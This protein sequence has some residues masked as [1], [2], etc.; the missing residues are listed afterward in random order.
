MTAPGWSTHNSDERPRPR[1]SKPGKPREHD[2]T[3]DARGPRIQKVLAE[4]GFGSRRACEKLIE[5]GAVTVN[6]QPV[7]T[8]PAWVDPVRDAIV[9]NGKRLTLPAEHHYIMLYKP[10][11][12]VSTNDDPEGRKL[13][14]DLVKLPNRTRL[15]PVGRL[16]MDSTGLLLLT[17]DGELANRLTHPRYG[18]H[19]VYEV[20][21]DGRL[22]EVAAEKLSRG[23]FLSDAHTSHGKRH[24]GRTSQSRLA[25]V[26]RDRDRTKLRLEL[27]EGRNRQIRRMM[28]NVGLDVRSLRRVQLG[29]LKLHGLRAG[30]WRELLPDEVK[31]LKKAASGPGK[32]PPRKKKRPRRSGASAN[33]STR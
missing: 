9:V 20:I 2:F 28:L 31:A 23:I 29:P 30:E 10:R 5:E 33:Q 21:V 14:I 16:D 25:I 3:D 22:D 8:L 26:K 12:V 19:K 15:Y 7:T 32:P 13:A 11:G 18:V 6:G 1:R 17:N 4:A 24:G 27:R